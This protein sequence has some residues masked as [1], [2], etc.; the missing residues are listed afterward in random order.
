MF[1][2]SSGPNVRAAM[3]IARGR[4]AAEREGLLPASRASQK[5]EGAREGERNIG[6]A[7]RR[8][9]GVG[10]LTPT[11]PNGLRDLADVLRS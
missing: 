8:C 4:T 2:R 3:M 5:G 6:S 11:S 10:G 9:A 1:A 7:Q